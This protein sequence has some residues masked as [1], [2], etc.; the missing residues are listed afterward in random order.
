MLY[1]EDFCYDYVSEGL[2]DCRTENEFVERYFGSLN[3]NGFGELTVEVSIKDNKGAALFDADKINHIL[4]DNPYYSLMRNHTEMEKRVYHKMGNDEETQA[5][6]FGLHTIKNT[7]IKGVFIAKTDVLSN[8]ALF[9]GQ[10]NKEVSVGK[11]KYKIS[12]KLL[13]STLTPTGTKKL[14]LVN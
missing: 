1:G 5:C 12:V 9:F 10:S 13:D 8:A 7:H 6:N 3:E 11:D 14:H 2:W 4:V